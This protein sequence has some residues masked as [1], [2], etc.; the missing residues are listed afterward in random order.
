MEMSSWFPMPKVVGLT[1]YTDQRNS[2]SCAETVSAEECYRVVLGSKWHNWSVPLAHVS[3]CENRR[4]L[5]DVGQVLCRL[6]V[7]PEQHHIPLRWVGGV[8]ACQP[9]LSFQAAVSLA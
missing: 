1:T 4:K 5:A 3:T 7:W 6:D 9:R 8:Y 2:S